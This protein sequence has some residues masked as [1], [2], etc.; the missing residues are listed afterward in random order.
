MLF[1]VSSTNF[2]ERDVQVIS[3]HIT[4]KFSVMREELRLE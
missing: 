3:G 2:Q 4:H 1:F